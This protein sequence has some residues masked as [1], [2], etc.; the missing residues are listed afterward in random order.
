VLEPRQEHCTQ[1]CAFGQICRITQS[2][3]VG[4]EGMLALP[5]ASDRTGERPA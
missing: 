1:T 5:M 4:K 3:G 2:R